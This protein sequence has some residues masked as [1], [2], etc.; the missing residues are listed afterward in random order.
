MNLS[1]KLALFNNIVF[2]IHSGCACVV[3]RRRKQQ[4]KIMYCSFFLKRFAARQQDHPTTNGFLYIYYAGF[5]FQQPFSTSL[6]WNTYTLILH[7]P[8]CVIVASH[9]VC[10]LHTMSYVQQ[11]PA[12]RDKHIDTETQEVF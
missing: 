5:F 8:R 10:N 7:A 4:R 6:F 2:L 1:V 9:M 11:H 3:L 12:K